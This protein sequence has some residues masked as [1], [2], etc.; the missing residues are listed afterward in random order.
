MFRYIEMSA[1]AAGERRGSAL[2]SAADRDR[3]IAAVA[4]FADRHFG[5]RTAWRNRIRSLA[6]GG[7]NPVLWGAGSRG[8]QFLTFAD[9]DRILSAV[10]DLNPRK[11]GRY[12]PVTAHRVVPPE[13]LTQLQPTV[14][15]ITNPAYRTEISGQLAELGVQAELLIA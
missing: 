1:N 2:P 15:I 7:A 14:V 11:W 3:Q 6:S 10:V 13:T 5:E 4:G 9:P 8:V 12:L